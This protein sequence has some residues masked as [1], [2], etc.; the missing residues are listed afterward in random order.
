MDESGRVIAEML[1][2]TSYGQNTEYVHKVEVERGSGLFDL[3]WDYPQIEHMFTIVDQRQ[4]DLRI[5]D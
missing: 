5:E 3:I 2:P 4:P 1:C